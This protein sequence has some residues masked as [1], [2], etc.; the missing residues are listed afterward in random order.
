VSCKVAGILKVTDECTS[1]AAA[2]Q[3]LDLASGVE[4]F[5]PEF[6]TASC[7]SG[8]RTSGMLLSSDLIE[9][10]AG[11]TLAV[12]CEET[13]ENKGETR[14]FR[15][16]LTENPLRTGGRTIFTIENISR[17]AGVRVEQITEGGFTREFSWR[18]ADVTACVKAY[19]VDERCS[20]EV[21]FT[22]RRGFLVFVFVDEAR[23]IGDK[24]VVG[25]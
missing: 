23:D 6:E 2:T 8:T 11:E 19:A 4:L 3:V 7:S 21:T 15:F 17:R 24:T 20:W 25:Q 9:N 16:S 22:G 5:S 14:L 12:Q 10:P 1:A 13:C 18:P